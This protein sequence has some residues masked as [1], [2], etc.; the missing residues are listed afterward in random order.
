MARAVGGADVQGLPCVPLSATLAESAM[1]RRQAGD[2]KELFLT[3]G[4]ELHAG[5]TDHRLGIDVPLLVSQ[6]PAAR[7]GNGLGKG[8]KG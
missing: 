7:S 2:R 1:C 8:V 3:S 5:K 4:E 6:D